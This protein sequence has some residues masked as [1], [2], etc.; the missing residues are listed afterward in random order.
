MWSIVYV[1]ANLIIKYLMR[2]QKADGSVHLNPG[3]SVYDNDLSYETAVLKS[4][5]LNGLSVNK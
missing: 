1:P 5:Q 4:R 2:A 3:E